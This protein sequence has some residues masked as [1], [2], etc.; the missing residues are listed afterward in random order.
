MQGETAVTSIAHVIQLS[1][2]QVFLL[3]GI[4]AL[5]GVLTNRLARA[6]DRARVLE[7]RVS[8]AQPSPRI[9][10]ELDT[11]S[12]RARLINRGISA[13]TL[14]ALLICA[15]IV[16]LFVDAVAGWELTR[17]VALLF[18]VAMGALILGLLY[19]LREVALATAGLRI[20]DAGGG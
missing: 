3:T 7:A 9:R 6:V 14:A 2:A 17:P 4:G 19:F 8:E 10:A 18:V 20:G 15:L 1:V 16:L 5:L 11:L 12:Q 13:V